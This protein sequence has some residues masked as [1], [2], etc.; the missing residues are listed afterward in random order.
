M[1][2]EPNEQRE[3]ITK[4]LAP[5]LKISQLDYLKIIIG[6]GPRQLLP[7]FVRTI[8]NTNE[9]KEAISGIAVHWYHDKDASLNLLDKTQELFPDKFLL[10]TEASAGFAD[11]KSPLSFF[12]TN[13]N[14]YNTK[15]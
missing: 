3:W 2:W 10:Y 11:S 4:F 5:S 7:N 9:A 13:I 1:G 12:E 8:L 14:N 15:P 6:D